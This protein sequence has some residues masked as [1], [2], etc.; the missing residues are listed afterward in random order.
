MA[1]TRRVD[2][3]DPTLT[4]LLLCEPPT[5]IKREG[6]HFAMAYMSRD[7]YY[8]KHLCDIIGANSNLKDVCFDVP[9]GDVVADPKIFEGLARNTSIYSLGISRSELSSGV[10]HEVLGA[11][12]QNA[13]YLRKLALWRC[14]I[15]NQG[16][17]ALA[18]TLQRCVNLR[19]ISLS[20][21]L[22]DDD[23][24]SAIVPGLKGHTQLEKLDLSCNRIGSGGC[25]AIAAL[26]E[27]PRC[28]IQVLDLSNNN[29]DATGATTIA[30]GLK[31]NDKLEGLYL[32]E[33][34]GVTWKGY[35]SF[36]N[37]MCDTSSLNAT[38][39]S[40]HT[41]CMIATFGRVKVAGS[42]LY[43]DE[44]IIP[45]SLLTLIELNGRTHDKQVVKREKILHYHL[46]GEFNME[47]FVVDSEDGA[48]TLKVVPHLLSWV[49]RSKDLRS[50][51][52]M[53]RLV[54]QMPAS[55]AT[56][57]D[58][59][60]GCA[61]RKNK[62]RS[63]IRKLKVGALFGSLKKVLKRRKAKSFSKKCSL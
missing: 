44:G 61:G 49:G 11:F 59:G 36:R 22:I 21:C 34:F 20:S 55:C 52:A 60:T 48:M 63:T 46:E 7:E 53:Y 45:G 43:D 38:C 4:H 47:P 28:N 32:D 62:R 37:I 29:I 25:E 18:F 14:R 17:G 24:V 35:N 9:R 6:N 27:G 33:N 40:N 39:L 12:A 1:A 41:L 50:A 2:L 19:E 15:R 54:Q 3:N 58:D 57:F 8:M 56:P 26:L 10:G 13:I 5:V 31:K 16:V 42:M 23:I 30:N 51:S